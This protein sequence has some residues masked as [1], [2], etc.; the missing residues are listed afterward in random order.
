MSNWVG[1]AR[2][3]LQSISVF[4]NV[5][6]AGQVSSLR[7]RCAFETLEP[8]LTLAA[9]GLAT[10]PQIYSGAL[11]GKVV[12]TSG[13]HGFAWNGTTYVTGRP[14]YWQNAADTADGNLV[15]D[16][17]NQDQMSLFADYELRAA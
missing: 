5:F 15:E 7:R 8:R 17:G 2:G 14:D 9:S 12:F 1:R 4:R 3:F 16:L 10:T 6:D 11:N 13:G